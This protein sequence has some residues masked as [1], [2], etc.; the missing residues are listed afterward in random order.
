MDC[1]LGDGTNN[2]IKYIK[3]DSNS[4]N[5][6]DRNLLRN[7]IFPLI[8]HGHMDFG[9]NLRFYKRFLRNLVI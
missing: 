9:E 2:N 1:S 4:D 3:D 7:K 8:E 5:T 6:F